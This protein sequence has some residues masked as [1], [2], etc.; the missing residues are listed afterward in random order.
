MIT[1]RLCIAIT[2][3]AILSA[4][5]GCTH[6]KSSPVEHVTPC[7]P[8]VPRPLQDAR[9]TVI[10]RFEVD[11]NGKP[12]KISKVENQL[13]PDEPFVACI[14]GWTLPSFSKKS[15]VAY[16]VRVPAEGGWTEMSIGDASGA[17]QSQK[18]KYG[19]Q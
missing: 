14:E 1:F 17:G 9:F 4:W 10:F 6:P 2:L 13:L 11:E 16:F 12:N 3:A 7:K 18:Y 15:V 5:Q 19:T 8:P